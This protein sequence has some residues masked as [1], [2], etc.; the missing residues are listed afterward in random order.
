MHSPSESDMALSLFKDRFT[1]TY[2]AYGFYTYQDFVEFGQ[3]I[4]IKESRVKQM[5][6]EFANLKDGIQQLIDKS[7][8]NDELKQ[9]YKTYLDD[10]VKRLNM[11]PS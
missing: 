11:V 5:I 1:K 6:R 4:G 10:K 7:F 2:E 3:H 8:L 9:I